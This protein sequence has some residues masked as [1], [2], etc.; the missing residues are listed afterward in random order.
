MRYARATLRLFALAGIT[1]VYFLRWWVGRP[2]VNHST[3]G[4]WKWRNGNFRG[5]ARACS[6]LIGIVITVSNEPPK[7]PFLLVSNHLSYIDILVLAAQAD[8]TFIAKAEVARWPLIGSLCRS[9][10]TIFID[11]SMRRDIPIVIQQIHQM[12]Q[13]G[14][15]VVLFAEGTSTNGQRVLPF[16]T[17]LL[18]FAACNQMPVHFACVSY[19]VPANETPA[20]QSVCWWGEMT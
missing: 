1:A 12:L 8:C 9:M 6:R 17:S 4:M 13:G 2:F 3:N 16:K 20:D 14:L 15:G 11:R 18:E 5:W 19:S 10:D 7:A